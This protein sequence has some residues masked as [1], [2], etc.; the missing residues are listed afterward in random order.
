MKFINYKNN[1]VYFF[2]SKKGINFYKIGFLA[3][4][5]YFIFNVILYLSRDSLI[6]RFG[7]ETV[8]T[9]IREEGY[10]VAAHIDNTVQFMYE[11]TYDGKKYKGSTQCSKYSVG[12]T[13]RVIFVSFKPSFNQ[14]KWIM[15]PNNTCD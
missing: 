9:V 10:I 7:V 6:S 4:A 12:D 11:F 3:L 8:A 13:I 15:N 2:E 5:L 1:K 14:P